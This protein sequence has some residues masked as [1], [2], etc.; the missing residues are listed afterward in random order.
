[1]QVKAGLLMMCLHH[2]L[3]IGDGNLILARSCMEVALTMYL[4]ACAGDGSE[5]TRDGQESIR[6]A[7]KLIENLEAQT[8]HNRKLVAA[9]AAAALDRDQLDELAA[10]ASLRAF[11]GPP[12][13]ATTDATA[14]LQQ[15]Q[16]GTP[17]LNGGALGAAG[18]SANLDDIDYECE[19]DVEAYLTSTDDESV[20]S[21][22][23]EE[24]VRGFC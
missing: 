13:S 9:A 4:G 10:A 3:L 17:A 18:V 6:V 1:M 11:P 19:T 8:Q 22:I 20:S 7:G 24:D 16:G 5:L 2:C 14:A 23:S 12:A 15:Q 21:L